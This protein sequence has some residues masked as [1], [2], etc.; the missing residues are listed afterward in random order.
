[1]NQINREAEQE[2]RLLYER[3]ASMVY[4]RCRMFLKSEEDAWDATQEVFMK[5]ARSLDTIRKKESVYSWLLSAGTNYCISQLRKRKHESFDE[6]IHGAESGEGG[7]P[8]DRRMLLDELQKHFL[9]PWD[10]KVRQVVIYTYIDGYR[11]DEI[12]RLTGMGESTVRRHLTR[13]RRAAAQSGLR[14]ED[15][16]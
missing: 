8:Q 6:T 14:R 10:E 15:L 3:Y 9:A 1:M 5:L 4:R 12:A 11:Q 16:A 7:L 2:L 13:F